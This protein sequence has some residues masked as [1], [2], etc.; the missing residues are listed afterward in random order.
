[1]YAVHDTTGVSPRQV[2]VYDVHTFVVVVVEVVVAHVMEVEDE[3]WRWGQQVSGKINPAP[4][5]R[6]VLRAKM[7]ETPLQPALVA[8]SLPKVKP[9]LDGDDPGTPITLERQAMCASC[10]TLIPA[11]EQALFRTNSKGRRE[12]HHLAHFEVK[13]TVK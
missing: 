4:W 1:M 3:V 5:L 8:E 7:L 2:A 9:L 10:W 12:T 13:E 6:G 11:G